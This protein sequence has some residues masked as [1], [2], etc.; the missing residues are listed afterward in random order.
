MFKKFTHACVALVHKYLPDPFIFAIMLTIIA[1][2]V[3][4]PL[5]HQGPID[6]VAHWGKGAW[7]LLGFSM[8]MALVLVLGQ[9]LANAPAFKRLL[10]FLSSIPKTPQQ[11]IIMVT[12]LSLVAN[13]I[14]W[15]FGLII[16][17]I[18]AKELAKRVKGV[19]YA[20]LIAAAYSG[21]VIWHAGLSGS[22]P[23]TVAGGGEVVAKQTAGAITEAIPTSMT[24]FASYNLIILAVILVCLPLIMAKMMPPK[25]EVV[26]IDPA[27]LKDDEDDFSDKKPVTPAEKLENSIAVTAVISAL[28][29]TWIIY[30]FYK[31]GNLDL[32]IVNM[33]FLFAGI[34][35]HKTP[36]RYVR[37]ITHAAKSAAGIIL[38]F[39]F[40]AGIM[41]IM[42]G[43]SPEGLSLAGLISEGF[44]NIATA[45]TF[46]LFTFL[47]AGIVNVFVP[48]GGGQWAV[49]A[50]IMMPAGA[51]LG[52]PHSVTAM[53]IAWGDAWTN[54]I[55]PFWALPALGIAG[56]GA[57]DIM[58]YCIIALIFVGV[59]VCGGFYFLT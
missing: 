53:A 56:L 45:S 18:F 41:G 54:M 26:S 20:L 8:Q 12:V 33:I 37:A 6:M 23:L 10:V 51:Q 46:P 30:Y 19:D 2:I 27:I 24:I 29:L 43:K 13:W 38:Q 4:M 49:Q 58:G 31:G 44:V 42:V 9:A 32:N 21:F 7:S 40:Y 35:M 22:V 15:G 11:A 39:P 1:F 3:A 47:S 52:V 59:V 17:A 25:E 5:T 16:S 57:R 36:I 28:G 48:S 55:Q 14:N 50:P 34:I